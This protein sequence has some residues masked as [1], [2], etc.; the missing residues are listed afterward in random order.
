MSS[1]RLQNAGLRV[2]IAP[3]TATGVLVGIHLLPGSDLNLGMQW[4]LEVMDKVLHAIAFAGCGLTWVVALAKQRRLQS[5]WKLE[6]AV[7]LGS[8][9]LGTVLEYVQ[10]AW[11][12]GR[13]F[14]WMDVFADVFGAGGALGAF[15]AIFGHRPGRIASD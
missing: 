3:G 8:L 13:M 14:D 9:V 11:M 1:G 15:F 6:G 4:P 2:W 5:G 7:L 12:S 10:D